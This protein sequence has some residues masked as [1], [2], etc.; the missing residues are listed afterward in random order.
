MRATHVG[1]AL[2]CHP[3]WAGGMAGG[4]GT[5][6]ETMQYWGD[7]EMLRMQG[8]E[9]RGPNM[10]KGFDNGLEWGSGL[11]REDS[12]LAPGVWAHNGIICLREK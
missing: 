7:P 5:V 10:C 3:D 8:P 12:M 9:D 11:E 1:T 6:G 4:W 2:Q